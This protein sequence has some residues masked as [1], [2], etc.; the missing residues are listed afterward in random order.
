MV[1]FSYAVIVQDLLL[2]RNCN[3]ISFT[4]II[5]GILDDDANKSMNNKFQKA[6][7]NS[8]VVTLNPL[9]PTGIYSYQPE[10]AGHIQSP[11][12]ILRI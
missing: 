1:F 2:L 4:E 11:K 5:Q 6:E 10:T 3:D 8:S 12:T 9:L 7:T